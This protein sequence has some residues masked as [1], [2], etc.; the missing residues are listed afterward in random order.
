MKKWIGLVKDSLIEM[1]NI[2]SITLMAMLG[3]V[4]IILGNFTLMMGEIIKISYTFIPNTLVFYLFG[5]VV[6]L[7]YGGA[8]DILTFIVKPTGTFFFGFTLSAMITGL[9]YGFILYQRPFRLWRLILANT[10]H[11]II[12]KLCLNTLWLTILLGKGFMVLFPARA[13]K[14]LIAFP[15]ETVLMFLIFKGVEASG[16]FQSLGD[17]KLSYFK[18]Y[19]GDSNKNK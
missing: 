9:L 19:I 13:I 1:R 6:G 16:I 11:L 3:A 15:I 8:M 17:K 5:P 10:I 12:V 14:D 7:I 4:S 2:R 18:G